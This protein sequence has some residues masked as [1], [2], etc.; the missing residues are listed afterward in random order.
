[1]YRYSN[2]QIS[3]SDFKQPVGMNLKK[4]NRWIKK[5]QTIPWPEIENLRK[6]QRALLRLLTQLWDIFSPKEKLA[7]VQ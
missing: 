2:G 4:N 6:I 3:L 5:A 7:I 1:M